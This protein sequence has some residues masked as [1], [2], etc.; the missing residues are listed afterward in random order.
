MVDVGRWNHRF[1]PSMMKVV[2]K[3]C[4]EL[5]VSQDWSW[6]SRSGRKVEADGQVSM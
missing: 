1:R 3:G 5:E 6:R 2:M 4:D